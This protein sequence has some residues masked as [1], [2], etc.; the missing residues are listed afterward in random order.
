MK[1]LST[2]DFKRKRRL[3]ADEIDKHGAEHVHLV[4]KSKLFF[5]FQVVLPMIA[6][7]T[8]LLIG[9]ITWIMLILP[10]HNH[11]YNRVYLLLLGL[12]FIA[13]WLPVIKKYLDYHMDFLIVTPEYILNYDQEWLFHRDIVSLNM[14]N[15]KTVSVKKMGIINSLFNEGKLEILFEG[16]TGGKMTLEY[17]TQPET[18]RQ[19]IQQLYSAS[20]FNLL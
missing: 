12:L 5:M 2:F 6:V 11:T 20:K 7:N 8:G 19:K 9:L 13:I 18:I 15:I 17:V 16:D 4:Q 3:L 1:I 10:L 14:K